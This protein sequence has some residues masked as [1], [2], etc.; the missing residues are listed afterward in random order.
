MVEGVTDWILFFL[1][2]L[3]LLCLDLFVF[4]RKK[5]AVPLKKALLLTGFWISLAIIFGIFVYLNMG[6]DSA[7]EYYAAYVIE[8]TLSVDNMFVFLLIFQAFAIPDEYQHEA[9]FYGIIGAMAFRLAFIF[10]GAELLHRFDFMMYFFGALLILVAIKTMVKKD[11][12]KDPNENFIIR[13]AAKHMRTTDCMEDGRIFVRKNGLLYVTPIF[14]AIL[15]L[16]F[17]DI[18]F[19]IDSVPAVLAVTSDPFIAYTSNIFAILGLRSLYFALKGVISKFSYFKYGIGVILIFVGV[20]MMIS[21]LYHVPVL[22]SLIF[23]LAVL[24]ITIVASL[25]INRHRRIAV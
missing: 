4:N 12:I 18:V 8:E 21:G 25:A 10:A 7:M 6:A 20:K 1:L 5:E 3:F 13:F 19:A 15:A 16:E 23:I 17:T 24:T 22:L 11:A 2:I 9:L 14:L